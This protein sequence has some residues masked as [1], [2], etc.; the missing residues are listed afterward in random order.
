MSAALLC[1]RSRTQNER[2]FR[3][4]VATGTPL[5]SAEVG[6]RKREVRSASYQRPS[7]VRCFMYEKCQ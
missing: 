4:S 7:S 1:P 2:A 5:A 6:P 3:A